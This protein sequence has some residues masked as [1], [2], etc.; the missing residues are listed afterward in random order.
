MSTSRRLALLVADGKSF[1]SHRLGLARAARDAGWAVTVILPHCP[2]VATIRAEGFDVLET[3]MRRDLRAPWHDLAATWQIAGELRRRR[4][5]VVHNFALKP[6]L[7]GTLACRLAGCRAVV[8]TIA[9]MGYIFI[10]QTLKARLLRG[11]IVA[12]FRTLIDR[13]GTAIIVQNHD[14]L[15]AVSGRLVAPERV[16]LVRG[17]GVDTEQYVPL[18]EPQ[19]TPVA[20]LVSRML[21]DKGVGELVEAAR[22][23]RQRQVPIRIA[24]VGDTDSA[25]PRCIPPAQLE[26]WQREGIVEWWGYRSDINEVWRNSHIA[27]LPSYREGLPKAL[28]EAAS[29]GR[30]AVTT[31]APGCRELVEH[32]CNGLLVPVRESIPLADALEHLARSADDRRRLGAEARRRI[33]NEF[34]DHIVHDRILAIYNGVLG[35]FRCR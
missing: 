8:N 25:N 1:L 26:E 24:L 12:G 19:G 32:D 34:A 20:T 9:G 7:V 23:L 27:V 31:D 6:A 21:W 22:L 13:R 10:N 18:P 14:D 11:V 16:V 30:P 28:L 4:I 35:Q 17:S 33:E 29:C 3:I 15:K 5:D 2:E